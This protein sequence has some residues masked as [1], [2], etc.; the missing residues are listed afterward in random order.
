V[1]VKIEYV[2]DSGNLDDERLI[3]KVLSKTDIGSYLVCDS[4]Y[5][6]EKT[7]SNKLRHMFWFPDKSVNEGDYI[8]LY[9][10]GGVNGEYTNKGE[11]VTHTFHWGLEE[12]VWNKEG[13]GAVVF[14]IAEWNSKNVLAKK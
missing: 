3:L 6:S 7:V 13:D 5:T 12:T 11:T 14:E 10:K 9:T 2:K 4:T 1:K 8:A